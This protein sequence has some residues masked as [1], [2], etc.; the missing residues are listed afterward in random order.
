MTHALRAD[1]HERVARR[2]ASEAPSPVRDELIAYHLERAHWSLA[3]LG[4]HSERA[5]AIGREAAG[6][7]LQAGQ[8]AFVRDDMPAAAAL[9]AE[10]PHCSPKAT[11]GGWRR[12]VTVGRRC[13]SRAERPTQSRPWSSSR[14]RP[15]QHDAPVWR[16]WPSSRGSSTRSSQAPTP[17]PWTRRRD[18][19]SPSARPRS[20]SSGSHAR[21]GDVPRRPGGQVPRATPR[22]RRE[23][24]SATHVWPVR[25]R[26]RRARSTVSAIRCSTARRPSS[27]RSRPAPSFFDGDGRSRALEATSSAPS[28]A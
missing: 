21:G 8:R 1:L 18:A 23:R 22:G 24:R 12:Y 13:G 28:R 4:L 6:S 27:P 16:P 10:R 26:R 9:L 11:S 25:T 7:L 15:P 3:A 14:A 17:R 19:P 20:T 5:D 2:L